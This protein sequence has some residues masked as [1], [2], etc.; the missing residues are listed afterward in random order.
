VGSGIFGIFSSNPNQL[1]EHVFS[2]G[3]DYVNSEVTVV[4]AVP[5]VMTE[6][7]AAKTPTVNSDETAPERQELPHSPPVSAVRSN[8]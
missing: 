4:E 8:Y 7:K 2:P 5:R 3:T 6:T 1:P